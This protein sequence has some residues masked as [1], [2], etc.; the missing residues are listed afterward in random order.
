MTE[1]EEEKGANMTEEEVMEW[2]LEEIEDL[3]DQIKA[4]LGDDDYIR[5]YRLLREAAQNV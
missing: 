2:L 5:A 4:K 1:P 3:L